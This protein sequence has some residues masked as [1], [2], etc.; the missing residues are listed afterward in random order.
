MRLS[1]VTSSVTKTGD[2][3][4]SRPA[5]VILLFTIIAVVSART[6]A[7]RILSNTKYFRLLKLT[8]LTKIYWR[9]SG[10]DTEIPMIRGLSEVRNNK[11]ILHCP[12]QESLRCHVR[13]SLQTQRPLLRRSYPRP[14][15][16]SQEFSGKKSSEENEFSRLEWAE[17]SIRPQVW[18]VIYF[19]TFTG[20]DIGDLK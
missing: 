4:S 12:L 16:V 8:T 14:A 20:R 6:P 17:G 2:M 1:S 9:S 10:G 19:D 18:L 5:G 7:N 13:G 3:A 11:M 15:P